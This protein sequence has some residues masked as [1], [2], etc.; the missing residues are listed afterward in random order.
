VYAG[1]PVAQYFLSRVVGLC[2][3]ACCLSR[4]GRSRVAP[5][6]LSLYRL[7]GG[8]GSPGVPRELLAC[9]TLEDA[10]IRDNDW[11][12]LDVAPVADSAGAAFVLRIQSSAATE[13]EG[14]WPWTFRARLFP[15]MGIQH[16]DQPFPARS[17]CF[18][19]ASTRSFS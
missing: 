17:L 6:T 1:R 14:V 4:H 19:T 18:R 7:A 15:L 5:V 12:A 16:G 8:E 11:V 9:T 10:G 2:R 13:E 3:V